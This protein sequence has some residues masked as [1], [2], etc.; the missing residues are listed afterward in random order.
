VFILADKKLILALYVD[1]FLYFEKMEKRIQE[2]E[3]ALA[4][5]FVIINLRE[6]NYYL[7]I[8]VIYDRIKG[9]CY[10]H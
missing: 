8:N 5:K 9:I 2:M 6:S 3:A 7:G 1:D 4:K 10:L